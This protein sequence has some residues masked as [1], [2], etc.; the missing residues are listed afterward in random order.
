MIAENQQPTGAQVHLPVLDHVSHS[1]IS[2][3]QQCPLKWKF[4]YVDKLQEDFNIT[5]PTLD[6]IEGTN[7]AA[8]FEAI[9]EAIDRTPW[10]VEETAVLRTFTFHKEV[11]Y[12]DLRN[13]Q[14][15]ISGM[16]ASMVSSEILQ[17]IAASTTEMSSCKLPS[18]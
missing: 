9:R 7:C 13:N 14:D 2:C 1:S 11:I 15:A 6:Q 5:L 12:Q 3:F 16:F 17:S 4:R 18:K 10:T 8:V